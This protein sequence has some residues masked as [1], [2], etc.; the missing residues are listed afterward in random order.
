[1]KRFLFF[2]MLL[3]NVAFGQKNFEAY[4]TLSFS[5]NPLRPL[6]GIVDLNVHLPTTK[7]QSVVLGYHHYSFLYIYDR[8]NFP[9]FLN[10]YGEK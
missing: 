1:M 10:S 7:N 2:G 5:T 6:M 3:T 8:A 9:T 4:N